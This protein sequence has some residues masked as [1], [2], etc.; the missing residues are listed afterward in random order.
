MKLLCITLL[1]YTEPLQ[2]LAGRRKSPI[3][4]E[5]FGTGQ[6]LI[7]LLSL[8][9]AQFTQEVVCCCSRLIEIN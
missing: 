7:K 1:S 8:T 9:L 3:P 5:L 4:E 2:R 6:V